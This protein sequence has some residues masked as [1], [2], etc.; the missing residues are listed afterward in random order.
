M[1]SLFLFIFICL[2][3][4]FERGGG[5]QGRDRDKEGDRGSKVGLDADSRYHN[6]GWSSQT[7]EI[8][9]IA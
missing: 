1:D 7:C 2:M 5:E 3:F 8:K 6:V 9:S 4:I